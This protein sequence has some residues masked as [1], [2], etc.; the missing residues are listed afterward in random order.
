[1]VLRCKKDLFKKSI[2]EQFKQKQVIARKELVEFER[3]RANYNQK[4][5]GSID[6][7]ISTSLKELMAEG[8][9]IKE[10]VGQYK[11]A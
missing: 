6:S 9:I 2:V 7:L 11:K 8:F 1:M 3:K 5:F 4:V 10:K